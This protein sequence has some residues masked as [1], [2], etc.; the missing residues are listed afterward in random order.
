VLAIAILK[1]FPEPEAGAWPADWTAL[2]F[3][4]QPLRQ[5]SRVP[6]LVD[7]VRLQGTCKA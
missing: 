4:K 5:I 6:R 3:F 7:V 1:A 2:V